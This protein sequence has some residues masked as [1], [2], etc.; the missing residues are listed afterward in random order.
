MQTDPAFNAWTLIF[1]IAAVQGFFTA[2]VLWRWQRGQRQANR[3]LATLLFLFAVMMV[4]YVVFWTHQTFSWPHIS[5]VSV[6]FPFLYGPLVWLYLRSIYEQKPLSIKDA[7]IPAVFLLSLLPFAGW[8][9][10]GTEEK[11]AIMEQK[12]TFPG[13]P[14]VMLFQFWV[15]K[16]WISAFAAW[17]LWYVWRQ[18]KVGA[19]T[20]WGKR[21]AIFYLIF[22]LAY[23]SYF[24]LV[25]FPFFNPTWDYHISAV[26]TAMI[27]LIAYAGYA[28]PAVFDGF[29]WNEPGAPAKYRNSGLTPEASRS[30]LQNLQLLMREERAYHD[31]EISLDKLALRLH[32]SKH[33]V[34]QVINEQLGASFFDYINQLRIEEAKTLLAE[35]TRSD[36]HIIEI[37]YAVGFNNKVS[38]NAAFK[39]ATGM[40]PTEYRRHHSVSDQEAGPAGAGE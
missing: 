29:Q 40:T 12:A 2:F 5:N 16:I 26:M 6:Q 3:L 17:N 30:L 27:Y 34:S 13:I 35:T 21:I 24:V 22:V 23:I 15:R 4:E 36:F 10:T 39:K 1:L 38:F 28:Q 7:W 20:Q 8:Y 31:S 19:S 18:P 11:R 25:R 14:W 37:A 9:L 32:A 33:H